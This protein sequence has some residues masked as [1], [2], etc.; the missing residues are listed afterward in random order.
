MM[1]RNCKLKVSSL[2]EEQ[3]HLREAH[4]DEF[5]KRF[6]DLC[7]E[8]EIIIDY[9]PGSCLVYHKA[10]VHGKV[11]KCLGCEHTFLSQDEHVKHL[12]E[13]KH[14]EGTEKQMSRLLSCEL[15]EVSNIC[16]S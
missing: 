1:H 8:D 2:S 7:P 4:S 6:C 16:M 14:K 15:C 12:L 11:F 9:G 5:G 3:K 10:E 13:T